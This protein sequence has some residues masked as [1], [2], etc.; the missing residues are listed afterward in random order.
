MHQFLWKRCCY[1]LSYPASDGLVFL[2]EAL[3]ILSNIQ[4]Y[5]YDEHSEHHSNNNDDQFRIYIEKWL[6]KLTK[7]FAKLKK[8]AVL[9]LN[10]FNIL[11][12][13]IIHFLNKHHKYISSEQLIN[14]YK[15]WYKVI[16]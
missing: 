16:K 2:L 3:M 12:Q 4:L 14:I 8:S 7:I 1:Y 5:E 11:L 15:L 9:N 13:F 10:M 6:P